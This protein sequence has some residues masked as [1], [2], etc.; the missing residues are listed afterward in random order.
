VTSDNRAG[1][2]ARCRA[3]GIAN[4]LVKPIKRAALLDAITAALGAPTPSVET[5]GPR[6]SLP[7]PEAPQALTILLVDDSADNRLLMQA[8]LKGRPY[9]LDLCENGESAVQKFMT[10]RYDLVL[11]DMQMPV[12]DGYTATKAIRQWE[13]A[14]GT[15]ATPIIALTAAA[16]KEERQKTFEAGCTTFLAK[17]IKKATLLETIETHTRGDEHDFAACNTGRA[18]LCRARIG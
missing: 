11:M 10:G 4:Y 1:D 17:P 8:Y 9:Q 15:P 18:S 6:A 3:L 12:M 5:P 7:V 2:I 13:A 14:H 16:L